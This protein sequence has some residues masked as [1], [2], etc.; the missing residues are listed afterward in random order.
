LLRVHDELY[1]WAG[2]GI[3]AD[4]ECESEYEECFNKIGAMLK[5]LEDEFLS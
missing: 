3:V 4:S 5:L 1:A 2:G